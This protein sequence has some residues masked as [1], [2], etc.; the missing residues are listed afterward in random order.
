VFGISTHDGPFV[1]VLPPLRCI[2]W[3]WLSRRVPTRPIR[4]DFVARQHTI[5]SSRATITARIRVHSRR[6]AGSHL[7]ATDLPANHANRR[8]SK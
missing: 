1:N 3:F 6:F 7:R 8:E 4:I 5:E 2:A